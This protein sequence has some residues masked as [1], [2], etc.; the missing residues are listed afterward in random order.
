MRKF[1]QKNFGNSKFLKF[2]H[3]AIRISLPL[4]AFKKGD[5]WWTSNLEITLEN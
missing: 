5:F 3:S 4:P 2:P 1:H